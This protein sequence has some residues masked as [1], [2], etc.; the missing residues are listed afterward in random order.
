MTLSK[1][2]LSFVETQV[3]NPA[4]K[5][6]ERIAFE[7]PNVTDLADTYKGTWY[8]SPRQHTIEF[9]CYNVLFF[10]L[11]RFGLHLFRKKGPRLDQLSN[12]IITNV[13]AGH[14]MDKAVLTLLCG[15]YALT[16]YHKVFGDNFM[17]LLQPCH[18]NLLLLIFTMVGP[19]DSKVTK[20]AFNSYLHYIWATI[21]A[22]T[23][24]DTTE[25]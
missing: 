23:F 16:V 24:P 17:Y 15:S 13:L 8:L 11:F 6:V 3:V 10:V 18:V 25:N 5:F 7:M 21:F 19:K 2:V 9:V 4:A 20:M 12:S 14:V 1:T 22:L